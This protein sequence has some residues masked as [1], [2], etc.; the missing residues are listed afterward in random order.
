MKSESNIPQ[1]EDVSRFLK[2]RTGFTVRPVAGYIS[3]RDFL[4]ALAFRVF[5]CTQYIRH[6]KDPMYTP[7]PDCCHELLGHMP[8]LADPKF[9]RFSHE[10]GL[11]SLG[12]ND[13]EVKKLAT[14]YFF[15]I[16]FGLCRQNGQL[17]AYG[18]G[19]LSSISELKASLPLLCLVRIWYAKCLLNRPR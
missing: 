4:S 14:C 13:E 15:T 9:A 1:L 7:E 18:A 19:L 3:A 8:M 11:A 2:S 17:R 12:V 10:I 6:P 5:Y 16:E